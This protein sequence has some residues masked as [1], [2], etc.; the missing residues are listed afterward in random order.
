MSY[1]YFTEGI[2]D[3]III[4]MIMMS[5]DVTS[6]VSLMRVSVMSSYTMMMSCDSHII[7]LTCFTNSLLSHHYLTYTVLFVFQLLLEGF[8]AREVFCL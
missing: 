6:I 1:L 5:Y 4:Y 7:T 2:F 3:V 8:V